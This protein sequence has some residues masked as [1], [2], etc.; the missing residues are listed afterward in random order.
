MDRQSETVDVYTILKPVCFVSKVL[1]LSPYIAVGD[2]G[3]SRIIVTVSA[4]IYSIG[5]IILNVGLFAYGLVPVMFTWTTICSTTESFIYFQ[6]LCLAL[7]AYF[8]C[9]FGCKRSARHF[10]KLNDLV[11]ETSY[12]VWRKDLQ[13]LL[14]M[15]MLC[16]IM[17][18]TAGV[19]EI[20]EEISQFYDFRTV[21]VLMLYCVLRHRACWLHVGTSICCIYAC[22]ETY[23]SELEKPYRYS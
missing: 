19:L 10:E 16:V 3:N 23:C 6:T 15:Q 11:G 22:T 2:V 17:I 4:V 7:S 20:S 1:G 18:V 9:L 13:L 14:A 21:L 8:T 12:S 5:K